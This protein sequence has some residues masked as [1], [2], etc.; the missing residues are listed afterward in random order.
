MGKSKKKS[1]ASASAKNDDKV[2]NNKDN[3]QLTVTN[4]GNPK[5]NVTTNAERLELG[6]DDHD[7]S[8]P[9][10]CRTDGCTNDAVAVGVNKHQEP[11][12]KR[13]PAC[14]KCQRSPIGAPDERPTSTTSNAETEAPPEQELSP[15]GNNNVKEDEQT[16]DD[17]TNDSNNAKS[18]AD[19]VD[20][21]K[22][23]G[24]DKSSIGPGDTDEQWDLQRILTIQDVVAGP[25]MCSTD[26]CLLHAACVY[27]STRGNEWCS[28]LDCQVRT[29]TLIYKSVF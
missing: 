11:D 22:M 28:C 4:D 24:G 18:G 29:M 12:D 2:S 10:I 1:T 7:K 16:G 23:S 9:L 14:E 27:V 5:S 21:H 20:P 26:K 3:F 15:Q 17:S 25:V 8:E 19:K 6:N 13:P